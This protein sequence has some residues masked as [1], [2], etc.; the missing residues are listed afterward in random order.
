MLFS[1]DRELCRRDG[2]SDR[3]RSGQN[4]VSAQDCVRHIPL[5]TSTHVSR[6]PQNMPGSPGE[7][8]GDF[9]GF[10]KAELPFCL[11]PACRQRD[12]CVLLLD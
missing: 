8:H 9:A 2:F 3:I 6:H 7:V 4:W 1:E 5:L 12:A 10:I 11:H